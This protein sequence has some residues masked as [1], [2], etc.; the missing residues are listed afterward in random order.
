MESRIRDKV[1]QIAG[2]SR[3]TDDNDVLTIHGHIDSLF[4]DKI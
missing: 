3:S 4:S 1:D 2:W